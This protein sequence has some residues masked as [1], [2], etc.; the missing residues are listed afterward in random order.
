MERADLLRATAEYFDSLTDFMHEKSPT[1]KIYMYISFVIYQNN[2]LMNGKCEK[3]M[4]N[5][6][7]AH[8]VFTLECYTSCQNKCKYFEIRAGK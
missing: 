8:W 3:K 5:N 2:L 1:M 6:N 7:T 4:H